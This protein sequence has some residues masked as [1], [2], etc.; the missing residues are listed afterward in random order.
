M[1]FTQGRGKYNTRI[2]AVV[3]GQYV[4]TPKGW[5]LKE[6]GQASGMTD[7]QRNEFSSYP[8]K[9]IARLSQSKGWNVFVLEVSD[10]HNLWNFAPTRIKTNADGMKVSNEI[11]R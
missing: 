10:T 8:E 1:D 2:G 5:V 7:A 9:Y 11:P 3:F 6:L 4:N